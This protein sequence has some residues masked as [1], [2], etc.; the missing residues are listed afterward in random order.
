MYMYID[1][2]TFSDFYLGEYC[3]YK[4]KYITHHKTEHT[5]CWNVL[6]CMSVSI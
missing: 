5:E 2:L 3:K 6:Y 1:V 4:S